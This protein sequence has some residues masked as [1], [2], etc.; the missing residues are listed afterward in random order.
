MTTT[1]TR[2]RVRSAPAARPPTGTDRCASASAPALP[3]AGFPGV[4]AVAAAAQP[5]QQA[6][7]ALRAL[8][9]LRSG[10][11][12]DRGQAVRPSGFRLPA[13]PA[14]LEAFAERP[15]CDSGRH[16]R[17]AEPGGECAAGTAAHASVL[18][19]ALLWDD[20]EGGSGSGPG[21]SPDA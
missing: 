7:R 16:C 4:G 15:F 17:L 5:F 20:G 18:L 13:A 21:G 9:R 19:D 11:G 8:R 10:A 12:P 2:V 3:A 14:D 1:P 6:L